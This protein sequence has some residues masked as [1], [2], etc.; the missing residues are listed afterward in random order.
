MNFKMN[1]FENDDSCYKIQ[2]LFTNSLSHME[3]TFKAY[4]ILK[5]ADLKAG[6]ELLDLQVNPCE[7]NTQMVSS[8]NLVLNNEKG[9]K[10]S[11]N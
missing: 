11:I 5:E 7:S 4:S 8:I 3:A 2:L 6:E 10:Y 9:N 1:N